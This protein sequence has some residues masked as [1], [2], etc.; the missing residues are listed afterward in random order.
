[1]VG[2]FLRKSTGGRIVADQA[3]EKRTG[4]FQ[5]KSSED[6]VVLWRGQEICSYP[7]IEAFVDAH[8][9]GLKALDSNQAELLESYY[10][11]LR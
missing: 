7:S 3:G 10:R 8:L 4:I 9:E 6:F 1:M 5:R 2:C 11:T